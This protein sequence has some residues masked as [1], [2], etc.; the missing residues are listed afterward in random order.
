V[1]WRAFEPSFSYFTITVT[2]R[3]ADGRQMHSSG[4]IW[5][6]QDGAGD[7]YYMRCALPL[8]HMT[9]REVSR[10][11]LEIVAAPDVARGRS[12]EFGFADRL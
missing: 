1:G 5:L 7:P 12:A 9:C 6:G 2:G 11:E 8:D 10:T 4:R 3:N